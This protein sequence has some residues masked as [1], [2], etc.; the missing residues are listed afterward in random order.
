[1]AALK[2]GGK[3]CPPGIHFGWRMVDDL[4]S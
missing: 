1:M 4:F 3:G 2:K